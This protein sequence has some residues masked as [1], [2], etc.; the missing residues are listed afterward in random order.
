M[1]GEYC[2]SQNLNL[3]KCELS[4][5]ATQKQFTLSP[6]A[7]AFMEPQNVWPG[8]T[9]Y[10]QPKKHVLIKNCLALYLGVF[11][12]SLNCVH[13]WLLF[14]RYW[15]CTLHLLAECKIE[16]FYFLIDSVICSQTFGPDGFCE[17]CFSLFL[18]V[19]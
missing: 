13:M 17:N 9:S 11:K 18:I 15:I 6:V 5:D 3:L 4:F 8:L 16:R 1:S 19:G 7:V 14:L 10:N 12:C 2:N